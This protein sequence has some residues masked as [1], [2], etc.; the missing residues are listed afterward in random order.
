[1]ELIT[2]TGYES[3]RPHKLY[4]C[5]YC[6]N[7][8]EVGELYYKHKDIDDIVCPNCGKSNNSVENGGKKSCLITGSY[9]KEVKVVKIIDKEVPFKIPVSEKTYKRIKK[10]FDE[11]NF[12]AFDKLEKEL[13][14]N[15]T[16][17]KEESLK[18]EGVTY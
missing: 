2:I 3:N 12:E 17:Y 6:L 15:N 1:M 14:K 5:Q 7:R 16:N 11:G 9:K 10:E 4:E 13:I 18:L 8:I